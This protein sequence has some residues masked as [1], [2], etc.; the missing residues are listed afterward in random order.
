MSQFPSM[1]AR[2][3]TRLPHVSLEELSARVPRESTL[4][5]QH[6]AKPHDPGRHGISAE[7]E[8]KKEYARKYQRARRAQLKRE[9]EKK[10]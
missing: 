5:P 8:K 3:A 7:V 4:V 10:R 6:R 9:R 1:H 2:D